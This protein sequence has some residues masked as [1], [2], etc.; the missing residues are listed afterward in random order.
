MVVN[1]GVDCGNQHWKICLME[2]GRTVELRSFPDEAAAIAY[3]K[4]LC[5]FY[6][7]PG[8][9]VASTSGT[10][11]ITLSAVPRDIQNSDELLDES[12]YSAQAKEILL[13]A[14]DKLSY[15]SYIMPDVQALPDI[16]TFRK[17]HRSGMGTARVLGAVTT[18][19]YRLRKQEAIWQEM[20]F[21]YMEVGYHASNI[22]VV[23][24]GRIVDG[25]C[26]DDGDDDM[27]VQ[28]DPDAY[29]AWSD[30][31]KDSAIAEQAYWEGLTEDLAGLMAIHHL[32]DIVI[33]GERKDAAIERLGDRYQ[34]YLYPQDDSES[35]GFEAAIGAAIIA[36]GMSYAGL[37][38]EVV[39]RLQLSHSLRRIGE[40]INQQPVAE[41]HNQAVSIH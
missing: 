12:P 39:E 28:P 30:H 38:A 11:R 3:L 33:I 6:P 18:L 20:R 35:E 36:E 40:Q 37:A 7:E 22:I 16:P 21:L 23:E 31:V 19:I 2:D 5:G 24:D 15:H 10:N 14:I 8:L 32:E 27:T 29:S 34:F 25:I 4:Q 13:I 41:L 26:R 17:R 9:L 1:I